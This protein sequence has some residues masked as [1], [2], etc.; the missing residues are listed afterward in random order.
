MTTYIYT[1]TDPLTNEVR[2]VG[3]SNNPKERYSNHL[4]ATQSQSKNRRAWVLG[5]KTQGFKPILHIIDV[6]PLNEWRYWER[7][8]IEQF[9]AWQFNLLNYQAGGNGTTEANATSFKPNNLPWN[10]GKRYLF[11]TGKVVYQ[12]TKDKKQFIKQWLMSSHAANKLNINNEGIGRCCRG[13][14]KSA[15]G[16]WW[17]Y[18][19]L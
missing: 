18:N 1:L 7:F 16:Y 6:V 15:G 14:A 4:R 17:S 11:K 10:K 19:K 9:K 13:L 12:Y 8:W 5:L 2:Y 3:K